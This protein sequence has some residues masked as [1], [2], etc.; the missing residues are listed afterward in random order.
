[1]SAAF[2]TRT[3]TSC[4]ISSFLPRRLCSEAG[5]YSALG[6]VPQN[7]GGELLGRPSSRSGG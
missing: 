5:G 2:L 7:K 4:T 6:F 1:M 3:A